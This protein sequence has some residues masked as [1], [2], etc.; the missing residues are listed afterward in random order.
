MSKIDII[1]QIEYAMTIK[2]QKHNF[3]ISKNNYEG[4]VNRHMNETGG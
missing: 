3:E 2:P 1:K 4:Y